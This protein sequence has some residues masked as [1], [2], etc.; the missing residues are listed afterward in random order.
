MKIPVLKAFRWC[1]CGS[2]NITPCQV[3]S[4]SSLTF[5]EYNVSVSW[6][7]DE[8]KRSI[9]TLNLLVEERRSRG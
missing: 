3:F 8:Y 7:Y 6:V 9:E 2:Y 4:E 1:F 5:I